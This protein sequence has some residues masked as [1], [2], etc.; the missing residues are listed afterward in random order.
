MLADMEARLSRLGVAS[1]GTVAPT[2]G[3]GAGAAWRGAGDLRGRSGGGE[4]RPLPGAALRLDGATLLLLRRLGLKTVGALAD[5]PRLSL[6]RRF[7][8][9]GLA[10]IPLPRLDQAMGRLAEPVARPRIATAAR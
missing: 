8:C 6:T 9:E 10:G 4:A 1:R 2:W 5:V 3:L 7:R